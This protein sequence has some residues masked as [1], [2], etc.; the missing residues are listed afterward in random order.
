MSTVYGRGRSL[1]Q[2]NLFGAGEQP[3]RGLAKRQAL[4]CGTVI[5][6]ARFVEQIAV[7]VT[8]DNAGD[9]VAD[10]SCRV[11]RILC[12]GRHDARRAWAPF[13]TTF[14]GRHI[15]GYI[16]GEQA[17]LDTRVGRTLECRC[18]RLLNEGEQ[19]SS[20][21]CKRL[22]NPYSPYALLHTV[23]GRCQR[24]PIFSEYLYPKKFAFQ[25]TPKL[26][27]GNGRSARRFGVVMKD[28]STRRNR[29][30]AFLN[31]LGSAESVE[32]PPIAVVVAFV[33]TVA[34]HVVQTVDRVIDGDGGN[35]LHGKRKK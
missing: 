12:V 25:A 8:L 30:I 17:P 24:T 14:F 21:I 15:S 34:G 28:S 9:T 20:A 6:M 19:N 18:G 13:S 3:I 11:Q 35:Y 29:V 27:I 2:R 33:I 1:V 32:F 4:E 22:L 5:V 16:E 31:L 7:A 26:R 23:W 10:A